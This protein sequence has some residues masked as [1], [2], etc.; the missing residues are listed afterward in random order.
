MSD[1]R[2]VTLRN[3]LSLAV[4][5]EIGTGLVLVF[6]PA[7]V[8]RLLLGIEVSAEGALLG[9]CFG[10]AVLALGTACWPGRHGPDVRSAAI[11]AMVLYNA[12]IGLYLIYLGTAGHLRGLLLWP[13]V[14]LHAA[15]AFLLIW[16]RPERGGSKQFAR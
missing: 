9:R 10:I 16:L 6:D 12:L 8:I 1:S 5:V 4:I 7:I 14:V 13:G 15:V 2:L 3:L 11:R